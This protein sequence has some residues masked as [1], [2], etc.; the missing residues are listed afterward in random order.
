VGE[1]L[2]QTVFDHARSVGVEVLELG[3]GDFNTQAQDLYRRLGFEPFGLERRALKYFD[4]YI[5]EVLMAK[6]L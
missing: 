6:F 2:F 5:D 1:G 3:V 4:R